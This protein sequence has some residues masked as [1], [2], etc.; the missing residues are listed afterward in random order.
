MPGMGMPPSLLWPPVW[1]A[2][3]LSRAWLHLLSQSFF[4][5][6]AEVEVEEADCLT[7]LRISAALLQTLHL[8]GHFL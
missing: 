7:A 8:L 1:G 6:L 2:L 3:S 4:L 5:A